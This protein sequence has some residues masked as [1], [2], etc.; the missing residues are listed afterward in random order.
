MQQWAADPTLVSAV[1]EANA[2]GGL[3]PGMTV[4]KWDGLE[5][6]D[7]VVKSLQTSPAGVKLA[8]LNQDKG[9]SK[10]YLRDEKGNLVASTSK[11][12][13][14][15]NFSRPQ[16]ASC[17]KSEAPWNA[18]EVKS[19]PS[20]GVKGVHLCVPVLDGKHAIGVLHSSVNA[21]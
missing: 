19:D 21:H 18:N 4:G 15:N 10:L 2:K 9:I 11:P 17:F 20:T 6:S 12:L 7:P 3:L 16:F 5:E 8:A 14:F 1:K 13:L